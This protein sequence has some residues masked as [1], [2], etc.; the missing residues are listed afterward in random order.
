MESTPLTSWGFAHTTGVARTE[1]CPRSRYTGVGQ[2]R[3][4]SKA[5]SR[6]WTR[7]GAMT[8]SGIPWR[9]FLLAGQMV[10]RMPPSLASSPTT[11]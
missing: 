8:A 9:I 2:Q 5:W 7:Q 11:K 6:Y 4:K 1:W 3:R 10:A